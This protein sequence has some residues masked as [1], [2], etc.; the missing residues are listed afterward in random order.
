VTTFSLQK[1]R[2]Y[3][4]FCNAYLNIQTFFYNAEFGYWFFL[5]QMKISKL[6]VART[7]SEVSWLITFEHLPHSS[8]IGCFICIVVTALSKEAY[9]PLAE[10]GLKL[11]PFLKMYIQRK[12]AVLSLWFCFRC[13]CKTFCFC[14]YQPAL[15]R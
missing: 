1:L 5:T 7:L 8:E 2:L 11:L 12:E 4:K 14:F 10:V 3:F 9:T 13:H 6:G 15:C